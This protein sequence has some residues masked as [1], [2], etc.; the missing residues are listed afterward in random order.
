MPSL[1]SVVIVRVEVKNLNDD[2]DLK[3]AQSIFNGITIEGPEIE[4][5]PELDLFKAFDENIVECGNAILDMVF[6]EVPYRLTVASPEQLDSG[7]VPRLFHSAG[8]KGGWGGPVTRHSSY[9]AI[10]NGADGQPL[11]ASKGNYTVTFDEPPVDAFWSI[12]VYDTETGG[13]FHPNEAN[14]YHINNTTAIPNEP[15]GTADEDK[16]YT[17]LFKTSCDISDK[18]CLEVPAGQF[19]VTPRYYLPGN[20]IQNGEWTLPKIKLIQ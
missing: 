18:N 17:F 14:R 8:T 19:D 3:S 6:K 16:T 2:D 13:H 10:F 11:D 7:E 5:F 9:E 4:E 15:E 1:I 20:E 12:T